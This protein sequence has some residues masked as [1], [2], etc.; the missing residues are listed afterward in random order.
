[1]AGKALSI[2]AIPIGPRAGL[3]LADEIISVPGWQRS[4][5][6]VLWG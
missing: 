4:Q 1:M 3:G 5:H 6:A 2:E